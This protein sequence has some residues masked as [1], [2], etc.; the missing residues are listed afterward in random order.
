MIDLI[1]NEDDRAISIDFTTLFIKY[2]FYFAI[3]FGDVNLAN[4]RLYFI[5]EKTLYLFHSHSQR[6][7]LHKKVMKHSLFLLEIL[8]N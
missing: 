1:L 7:P 5:D 2:W 3:G 4:S 6:I 8:I